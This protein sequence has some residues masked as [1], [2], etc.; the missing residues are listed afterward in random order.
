M[1]SVQTLAVGVSMTDQTTSVPEPS[2]EV[3]VCYHV[4]SVKYNPFNDVAQCHRCGHVFVSAPHLAISTDPPAP[5][6]P[7]QTLGYV[8]IFPA[9]MPIEDQKAL[10]NVASHHSYRWCSVCERVLHR[11]I[12]ISLYEGRRKERR[13]QE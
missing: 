7:D 11:A 4:D 6:M 1:R 13:G 2:P 8:S 12:K 10:E 9:W 3:T 5:L